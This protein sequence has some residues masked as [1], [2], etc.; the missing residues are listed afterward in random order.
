MW[1]SEMQRPGLT[2]T[3]ARTVAVGLL[4]VTLTYAIV[5][6]GVASSAGLWLK[7]SYLIPPLLIAGGCWAIVRF[8]DSSVAD[9]LVVVF[10][11]CVAFIVLAGTWQAGVSDG[12]IL[13]GLLPYSDAQGYYNDALRLLSGRRFTIFSSRRPLFPTF[14]AGLLRL[15]SLDLRV[16]LVLLMGMSV[17]A[18]CLAVR[19]VRRTLGVGSGIFMLLCLFMFYR[20]YIGTTLT[21]HLGITFGCL[22]FCLIW[23]GAVAARLRPV[24]VGLFFLSLGLNARAGAFLILPAIACWAAWDLRGPSRSILRILGSAAAAIL[25]GF[26]VNGLVLQM[27]AI[28]GAAYSNFS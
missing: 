23:R 25:L 24:L 9:A 28:P 20:R 22:A 17:V 15:T 10:T 26:A 14:L 16:A 12:F 18:I 2:R 11:L 4:C 5:S 8:G 1:L 3:S 21:E 7:F 19:E 6:F 27:V 13:G